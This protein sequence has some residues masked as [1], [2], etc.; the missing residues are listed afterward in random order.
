MNLKKFK[1]ESKLS[2]APM[3]DWTD[4]HCRSFHR[5]LSPHA[6]L[7]TE[8]IT[9]GA[10]I[11]GG[12]EDRFLGYSEA[13]HPI[14]LQLGGS[15][16]ADLALCAEKAVAYNYD[17][18]NLNCGCPSDRVQNGRF[19]ACLMLDPDHVARCIE[20]M[21]KAAPDTPITIKCRIG[22]DDQ[23]D[24]NF[25]HEFVRINREAGCQSFI[26]HARKAFLKGLSPKENRDVP[27]L[28]YDV[29]RS[30][31]DAFPDCAFVLNGGIK[32]LE[33]VEEYLTHFDGVMI[34]REA[35]QNPYILAELERML[36]TPEW[37]ITR[38]EA[39]EKMTAYIREALAT[40]TDGRLH[41]KSIVRH[42]LG[43]YQGQKGAK[44]WRRFISENAFVPDCP[45]DILMQARAN[46]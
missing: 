39:V 33:E 22:V 3:L 43:L 4:R 44:R 17:E 18:I 30:V 5:I 26:V 24:E 36:F 16:P 27:P 41:P 38:D 25:L 28:R 40:S 20:A 9:T 10:I 21:I 42:V 2:V 15:D 12:N 23:D 45:T 37:S 14:A 7:Y 34:G 29:A 19:G 32:T 8:M 6:K 1:D 35:Y 46:I 13:E 11:H 31:K